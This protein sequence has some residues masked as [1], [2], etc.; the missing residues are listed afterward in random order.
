MKEK[1]VFRKEYD[2][3][4]KIWKYLAVFPDDIA[5]RGMYMAVPIWKING[6]PWRENAVEISAS[7]YLRTK[8]VHKNDPIVNELVEILKFFYGGEY[9]VMEKIMR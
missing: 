4:M 9:R 3:Y 2:P 5:R 6:Q 7:Y 1:V 8:V